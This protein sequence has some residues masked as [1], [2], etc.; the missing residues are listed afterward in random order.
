MRSFLS[1]TNFEC[2]KPLNALHTYTF[3]CTICIAGTLFHR[4]LNLL[5]CLFCTV[6]MNPESSSGYKGLLFFPSH[7]SFQFYCQYRGREV[8]R[9][10]D[11]KITRRELLP[12]NP[13]HSFTTQKSLK[14]QS[15]KKP[16]LCHS[17]TQNSSKYTTSKN[18]QKHHHQ[19][20][21]QKATSFSQQD[22]KQHR[23]IS[24]VRG[25]QSKRNH[26]NITT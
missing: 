16:Y 21:S 8:K 14:I 18:H 17:K 19:I 6:I 2:S 23:K 12:S 3:H 22:T 24:I 10:G 11:E 20:P 25:N 26:K 9:K 7:F 5:R 15:P 13:F 4:L 1:T